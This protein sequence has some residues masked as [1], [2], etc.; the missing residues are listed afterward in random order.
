MQNQPTALNNSL[1]FTEFLHQHIAPSALLQMQVLHISST[2]VELQAPVAGPNINIHQTAFAGSIYSV[3]ALAGWS[4]GHHRL[5]LEGM[6]ADVVMGKAEITYL[7]PIKEQISARICVSEADVQ[8]WLAKLHNKGKG[9]IV[10]KVEAVENG[11]VKAVL[12]G[13]LVAVIN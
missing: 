6:D 3:C 12:E 1:V 9:A 2:S 5:C 11:L 13:K 4:L 10:A 8:V 7:A